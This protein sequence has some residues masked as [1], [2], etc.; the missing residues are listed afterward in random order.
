[1][2]RVLQ[3]KEIRRIGDDRVVPVD[4]R[5]ISA[6]N[7]DIEK[8]IST[9]EFRADLFYRL[10]L[11]NLQAP[12]LRERSEDVMAMADYFLRL[13]GQEYQKSI[14]TFSPK[15]VALLQRYSWPGNARELRNFCEKLMV[16]NESPVVDDI[17]LRN[18]GLRASNPQPAEAVLEQP[19][20]ISREQLMQ[21]LSR[22][23]LKQEDLA[24]ML[25]VSRTTLWRWAKKQQQ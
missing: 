7:I 17:Q 8:Q 24:R 2:L 16:L 11:L 18:M 12:P 6:T 4:V 13:F 21:L 22:Q 5:V 14:P 3:E 20:N 15:A 25:G 1:M 19:D 23:K 10:N 9:R